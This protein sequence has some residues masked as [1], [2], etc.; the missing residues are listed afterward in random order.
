MPS[1]S[2]QDL[3]VFGETE[4]GSIFLCPEMILSVSNSSSEVK[5]CVYEQIFTKQTNTLHDILA[6]KISLVLFLQAAWR[7]KH[8]QGGH[9]PTGNLLARTCVLLMT[10]SNLV[11]QTLNKP[12]VP[13]AGRFKNKKKLKKNIN[14]TPG[15]IFFD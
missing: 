3:L 10:Y 8:I 7:S 5:F 6:Q 2:C 12:S 15:I 4:T 1:A 9:R 14:M 13:P 11:N